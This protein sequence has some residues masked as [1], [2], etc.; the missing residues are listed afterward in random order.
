M[1]APSPQSR[2]ADRNRHTEQ[3]SVRRVKEA[4]FSTHPLS[5]VGQANRKSN[6]VPFQTRARP[7]ILPE[8]SPRD[9]QDKARPCESPPLAAIAVDE[10]EMAR[11]PPRSR[12]SGSFR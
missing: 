12:P 11:R 3:G 8:S 6:L 7:D 2:S 1:L 5:Q 4:L 10:L 9:N